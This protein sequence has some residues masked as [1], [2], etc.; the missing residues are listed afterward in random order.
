MATQ[1]LV[2]GQTLGRYQIDRPLAVGGMA[3]LYLARAHGIEGFEKQVALKRI[4]ADLAHD[5]A[6][7]RMFLDEARLAAGLHHSHIAQ[8]FDIGQDDGSYYFTLEYID[9][10]DVRQ[11][12]LAAAAR[13][14]L[15]PVEHTLTIALAVT[16]ALSYAHEH[17]D[18]EGRPL[19]LVHRDVSPSNVLVSYNGEVKL[20]D[21]GIAKVSRRSEVT[22]VGTLKGKSDY[23]APEQWKGEPV[24]QRTDLFSL[25]VM[26]YE[27]TTGTRPFTAETDFALGQRVCTEDAPRPSSRVAGYSPALE[28]IVLRALAREPA[29][30][31][32]TAAAMLQELEA[33]VRDERLN[34][35]ALGLKTYLQRL[36]PPQQ[37]SAPSSGPADSGFGP[38]TASLDV[39]PRLGTAITEH[40]DGPVPGTRRAGRRAVIAGGV[41]LAVAAAVG[42]AVAWS[43]GKAEAPAPAP[44][45]AVE[46]MVPAPAASPEP[47]VAPEAPVAAPAPAAPPAPT[48]RAP[49]VRE[50][51]RKR[52]QVE[53]APAPAPAA[54][55][56]KQGDDDAPWPY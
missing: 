5:G 8:V 20:V 48:R 47:V 26:L 9:G 19:Q 23:M 14:E 10:H 51:K 16:A 50:A 15:I 42:A 44:A 46:A 34:V 36:L 6:N 37:G 31:Y 28:E 43:G 35:S 22:R 27:L 41:A 45:P 30:R 49:A 12:K 4:R 7:V 38:G 53:P 29:A 55:K 18:A 56:P 3:E 52:R 39:A 17:K 32:Q 21:F 1:A 33:L 54:A 40:Y 2:A 11:L 25:G 13:G 24:D